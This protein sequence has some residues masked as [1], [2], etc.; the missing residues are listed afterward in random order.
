[1]KQFYEKK[2]EEKNKNIAICAAARKLTVVM[3]H[4]LKKQ[5]PFKARRRDAGQPVAMGKP[6]VTRGKTEAVIG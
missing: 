4:I 2:A 6:D 3:W 5:V 1:M